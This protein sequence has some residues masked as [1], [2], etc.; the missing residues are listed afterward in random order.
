MSYGA[1][2]GDQPVPP[3]GLLASEAERERT[4]AVLKQAFEDQRLTQDEFESRVGSAISARTLDQLAALTR[5]LPAAPVPVAAPSR[6]PRRAWLFAAIGA[7]VVIAVLFALISAFGSGSAPQSSGAAAAPA[8]AKSAPRTVTPAGP[9]RCPVGTSEIALAIANSLASDPVYVDPGTS[10]LTP[11]QADR[12]RAEIGLADP[13]R[14]RLAAVS[15]LTVHRG[16]GERG[17]AN[18]ISSCAADG[19][20]VTVVT[21]DRSTYLV[22]SYNDYQDTSNAV[23]A[24]LNTHGSLAAGLKDAVHRMAAIDPGN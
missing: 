14:I 10:L 2:G 9:G 19:D 4:Q 13:G 11:A 16:G 22:T 23:G 21:T 12:L 3:G 18:A 7:A 17:L 15:S 6:R 24:A 20:G 1:G 8:K 5:D